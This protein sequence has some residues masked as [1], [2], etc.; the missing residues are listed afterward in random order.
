VNHLFQLSEPLSAF[1][2]QTS[3]CVPKLYTTNH[4]CELNEPLSDFTHQT[5]LFVPKL[6]SE[7]LIST[8]RTL[9]AFT[10]QTSLF[11]P[12]LHT[13]NHLFELSEPLSSFT[14]ETN[15]SVRKTTDSEPLM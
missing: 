4:L 14:T 10:P 8:E 6:H 2:H 15:V 9:S 11:V 5:S 1:T 13:E 3:L 12:K 7:P